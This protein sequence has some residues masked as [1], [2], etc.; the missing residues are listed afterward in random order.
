[1]LT[2][3]P[4]RKKKKNHFA[5]KLNVCRLP[6]LVSSC[7]RKLHFTEKIQRGLRPS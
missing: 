4:H 3:P 7:F 2:P 6:Y 1:L 5:S